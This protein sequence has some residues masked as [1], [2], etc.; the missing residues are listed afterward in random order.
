MTK[1][2]AFNTVV[3]TSSTTSQFVIPWLYEARQAR[4]SILHAFPIRHSGL[5][6]ILNATD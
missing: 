2:K 3:S 6:G 4:R 5:S 1:H